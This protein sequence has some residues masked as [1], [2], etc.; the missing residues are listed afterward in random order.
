M[1]SRPVPPLAAERVDH[2]AATM[3]PVGKAVGEAAT[4]TAMGCG[5][6]GS[7]DPM[8]VSAAV[9]GSLGC[10]RFK[11][12]LGGGTLMG[13]EATGATI[14]RVLVWNPVEGPSAE[15]VSDK[16]ADSF[17]VQGGRE[18]ILAV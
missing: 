14:V 9:G 17:R 8:A 2:G 15:R 6:R 10:E 1:G 4:G 18:R 16:V 13:A 3:A 11:R 12:G 5:G 7:D